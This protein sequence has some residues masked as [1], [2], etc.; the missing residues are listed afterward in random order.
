MDAG[1]AAT[2]AVAA[3][4]VTDKTLAQNH[5]RMIADH[6]TQSKARSWIHYSRASATPGSCCSAKASH[7]TSEFYRTRERISRE[8][9]SKKG[10][11]FVAIEGD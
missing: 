1:R 3:E 6:S 10:F 4:R 8:L 7:G 9:I 2:G 5:G 11:R